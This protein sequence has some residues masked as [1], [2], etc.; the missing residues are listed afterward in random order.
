MLYNGHILP[1]LGYEIAKWVAMQGATVILACR[2]EEKTRQ[3]ID[4]GI[5]ARIGRFNV[6]IQIQKWYR[7]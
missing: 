7:N 1:G 4:R 2:S 3:V 5:K 6:Y